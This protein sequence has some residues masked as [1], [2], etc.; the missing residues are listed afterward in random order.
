MDLADNVFAYPNP[1]TGIFKIALPIL[2]NKIK[3]EVF[4][5]QSQLISSSEYEITNGK[6]GLDLK[7]QSNG[8]YFIKVYLEEP[9]IIKIIKI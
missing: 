1:T 4:N 7:N 9:V 6:I 3:L 8:V 5:I 2:E